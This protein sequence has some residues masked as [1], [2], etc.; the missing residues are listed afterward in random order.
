[1][2]PQRTYQQRTLAGKVACTGLGLHTGAPVTLRLSPAR[3]DS[4]IRFL[5]RDVANSDEVAASAEFVSSTSNATTLGTGDTAISTVEHLLASLYALGV[6]NARIELDGPEVPVMDGSAASFVHLI[7]SAGVYEQHEPQ[8]VMQIERK[9]EFDDGERSISIEPARHLQ[10]SYLIDFPHPA[11]GL[12][13]LSI[14]RLRPATFELELARARTFGFLADV[15]ALRRAGLAGGASLANTV[16]LDSKSVV[17][18]GGLRWPDEFV[19]HKAMDLVGDL[20]LLGFPVHG[21]VRVRRGGH[22][23]H[24]QLVHEIL[25]Q[26]DAWRLRGGAGSPPHRPSDSQLKVAAP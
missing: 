7:Q 24:L 23:I 13:E 2:Y 19:R 4:G 25:R 5:R 17:N 6:S 18:P 21:H 15:E 22:S 12:Q 1:L 8:A 10:I 20:S 9:I 26:R 16:V 3:V 14:E 11:I